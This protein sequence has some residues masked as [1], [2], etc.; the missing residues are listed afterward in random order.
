MKKFTPLGNNVLVELL[1]KIPKDK[2]SSGFH[3]PDDW[4]ENDKHGLRTGKAIAVGRGY[5]KS[6]GSLDPLEVKVG[7]IVLFQW[8]DEVEI[9]GAKYH[10]VSE[11]QIKGILN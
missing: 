4:N 9:D 3:L 6:D 1:K 7:D 5:V 2:N 8:G 10:L 11:V